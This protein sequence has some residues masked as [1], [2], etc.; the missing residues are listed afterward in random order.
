MY[1]VTIDQRD[2]RHHRDRIGDVLSVLT[3]VGTVLPFERTAGD[4]VQGLFESAMPALVACAHAVRLGGW[5]IGLGVGAVQKPLPVST[6]QATGSAYI[7]ARD[8]VERAKRTRPLSFALG[9]P[10]DASQPLQ[11][12][13]EQLQANVILILERIA[14]R[15]SDQWRVIDAVTNAPG[16]TLTELAG[17]LGVSRQAVGKSLQRSHWAVAEE[18]LESAAVSLELVAQE[19][20]E[21]NLGLLSRISVGSGL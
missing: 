20:R 13:V 18:A 15:T 11:R 7:A 19:L 9:V 4:E 6:R 2:S 14:E 21:P 5:S 3:D 1:V 10:K 8:A 16:V 12:Y 17:T